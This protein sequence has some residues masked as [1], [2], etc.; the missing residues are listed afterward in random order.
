M[1]AIGK[2]LINIMEYFGWHHVI[3]LYDL[4]IAI[5][6]LTEKAFLD[7]LLYR[8]KNYEIHFRAEAFNPD[9]PIFNLSSTLEKT[10]LN[11]RVLIIYTSEELQ[12][13]LLF[14]AYRLEMGGGDYVFI[15][16]D[17]FRQKD[18]ASN[19]PWFKPND[20][21]N[22]VLRKVYESVF[23]LSLSVPTGQEYEVFIQELKTRAEKEFGVSVEDVTSNILLAGFYDCVLMY[24]W[25]VNT[26]ITE[27][28]DH[29]DGEK[30]SKLLWNHTFSNGMTG[31]IFINSNGDRES[32]YT[33]YD[34]DQ[35]T[36]VMKPVG[37][38]AGSK[39][40]FRLIDGVSVQWPG[41]RKTPPPDVPYCGFDGKA[42]IAKKIQIR[43]SSHENLVRFIG[44]CPEDPHVALFTEF[45]PRGNLRNLLEND[46]FSLDWNFRYSVVND[47]VEGM[48]FIHDSSI[49]YHGKLKSSN[50][51]IDG[52][53]VVKL[54]DFGL[55]S[56]LL[57]DQRE[58]SPNPRSYFWASPEQLRERYPDMHGSQKGDVYSFAIILQ[59]VVTR[60]EPYST[61]STELDPKEILEKIRRGRIPLFR[62]EISSDTCSVELLT[63]IHQ[64]WA[65][66]P[67]IRPS[68][69]VIKATLKQISR[70][71]SSGNF[72]DN[73]LN[74]MEQYASNLE[75]L[76]EEK[77][78]AFLEEKKKSEELLYQI[79]PRY[80][81]DQLRSG[82]HVQPETFESVTIYFSDI[83]GFTE[84]SAESSPME[85]I[86]LLND[87]YI[88]FDS[89][90]G[91]FD[92]YKVE[93]IG[94]AYMVVSGLPIRN[95]MN[96]AREI[97]RMSLK[98]R[99]A[100]KLFKVCHQP[101]NMLQLRIGIHS[102]V[103]A[104]GVVGLKM[105]RYCLFGDTVNTASRMETSGE[106]MKI[107]VSP[108]TRTILKN[109][110]TFR[111]SL[112]GEVTLKGKGMIR[113]YWLE[114]EDLE[115][116]T[117]YRR[118]KYNL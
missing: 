65:E 69:A 3:F 21:K 36:G 15:A 83:V 57:Q 19:F 49:S 9:K 110:G 73:L 30:V 82:H 64:C 31:D 25:A 76:V 70:E 96:H 81:A 50:C 88:T 55:R 97:A 109:F 106:P 89:I 23:T 78:Q 37:T 62:P 40:Q 59:E 67:S 26:T 102:G 4:R 80:V 54:T 108:D 8:N 99:D 45:C 74:R 2:A 111:I 118:V 7:S 116:R 93:T 103:C 34:M 114:G 66:D 101:Q 63:L 115:K 42:K 10:K 90:I 112:R 18:S 27:G 47:I 29:L 105:P 24:A 71:T 92:V 94:D 13:N 51:V 38:Y 91:N 98:L 28:G 107:H 5:A 77:T 35:A 52:H 87:L 48:S 43:N 117:V 32:D 61:T 14:E 6:E 79:L 11:T 72:M 58:Q 95:G 113:T 20:S 56:L 86:D 60:S 84:L 33:L 41:T 22:S 53:F 85:V 68:F 1:S 16:I 100:I 104:A 12:R 39:Q 46:R 44:M 17:L 75:H